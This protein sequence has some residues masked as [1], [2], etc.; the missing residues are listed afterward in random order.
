[1]GSQRGFTL[2][3]LMAWGG[4]L[5]L[6][7]VTA[8]KVTPSTIEY[9][10]ILKDCKAIIAQAGPG[11]TVGDLRKSFAKYADVDQLDFPP[12]QLD[13]YKE[14]EQVVIS[15]AY[16]KRIHLFKNVSFLIDYKGSTGAGSQ[17]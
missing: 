12:E 15:F 7:A 10:K 1:M 16:E 4:F 5:V 8:I 11:A 6:L 9:Y 14:G 17:E 2:S 3:G 13:I